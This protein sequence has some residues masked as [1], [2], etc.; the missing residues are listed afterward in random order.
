[1]QFVI[2]VFF[3]LLAIFAASFVFAAVRRLSRWNRTYDRLGK[4]Y[5][6][7]KG[8]RV[9][10][11]G[12][13]KPS[14]TFD[15]GRTFCA[16]RN[17]K[18]FRFPTGRQTEISMVWP[19]RKLR[20]EVSTMP[21]KN[22]NWGASS[23]QQVLMEDPHFQSD[24]YVSGND[25]QLVKRLL[26]TGVRWQIELLRRHMNNNDVQITLNRGS[27]TVSKPGFIKEYVALEDFL[28]YALE[29]FDQLMLVNAEGIEF[30][31]ANQAAVVDDV[32]CPIC[33]EEIRQS[34][35]VCARCKTPHCQDCW[36]YNGQCATFACNETRCIGADQVTS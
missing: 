19:N 1:M 20:F 10:G 34:M 18:S 12:L 22:R 30:V 14:L 27:L 24:F 36:Q 35:V 28:R 17:R 5:A 16:L 26:T 21:P 13:T 25:P 31:N 15:Y 2:L 23:M 32:K 33:S 7:K 6:G 11:F 8:K 29:L 4:R 3:L 9:V